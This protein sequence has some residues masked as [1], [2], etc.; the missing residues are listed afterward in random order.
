MAQAAAQ[1]GLDD[2]VLTLW[3]ALMICG[4]VKAAEAFGRADYLTAAGRAADYIKTNLRA[5][6]GRLYI[7]R[8]EDETK[9]AGIDADYAALSLALLSLGRDDEAMALAD[10]L[11]EHFYDHD[12]GGLYLYA[13]DA[14]QL[15]IRPKE[16]Y[17]GAIPSGNSFFL[18]VLVELYKRTKDEKWRGA[19]IKQLGFICSAAERYPLGSA[20]ALS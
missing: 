11:L 5:P 4:L 18:R 3:N 16:T 17:D 2:K 20:F 1:P 15:F 14:E 7:R 13:D 9:G 6:D 8:R 19:Y 10:M 12:A